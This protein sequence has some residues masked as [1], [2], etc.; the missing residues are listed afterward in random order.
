MD[1]SRYILAIVVL[2]VLGVVGEQVRKSFISFGNGNGKDRNGNGKII[3]S[4]NDE[5]DTVKQYLLNESPLYGYNRP[6]IWIHTKYE[7]NSRKWKSF[8]SRSSYDLNQPYI[9]LTIKSIIN[10]CGDDFNICLIDDDSFAKL[11]PSWNVDMFKVSDPVKTHLRELGMVQLLNYY[12]GMVLPN[13]FICCKNMMPFYLDGI[14]EKG[15]QFF[16]TERP[17]RYDDFNHEIGKRNFVPDN[18]IMG[19]K[20]DCPMVKEYMDYLKRLYQVNDTRIISPLGPMPLFDG[21]IRADKITGNMVSDT[22]GNVVLGIRSGEEASGVPDLDGPRNFETVQSF[23]TNE[24]EFTGEKAQWLLSKIKNHEIGLIGGEYVGVKSRQKRVIDLD[25]LMADGFLD[26]DN[27][28]LYGVFI[29]ADDLLIR[30]KYAWFAVLPTHQVINTH[31]IVAKYL[32]LSI[33]DS[34]DMYSKKKNNAP[35]KSVV[36]L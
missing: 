3:K 13:S 2:M 20:K 29:P 22:A 14:G 36:S 25:E 30:N 4:Q 1:Y 27:S 5:Y 18:Y 16:V 17:N 6:K 33:M 28:Q 21:I 9:H 31:T 19:C 32:K 8:Y 35:E 7:Y 11:I 34:A 15:D 23:Y 10:H 26:V 24:T 12:G